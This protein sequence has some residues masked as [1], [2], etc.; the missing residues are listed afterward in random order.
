MS[1]PW[2]PSAGRAENANHA[3]SG[4]YAAVSSTTMTSVAIATTSP[5]GEAVGAGDPASGSAG[6]LDGP[7]GA[8][9]DA[10]VG[11][12]AAGPAV[13]R[14]TGTTGAGTTPD[15]AEGDPVAAEGDPDGAAVAIAIGVAPGFG[16]AAGAVDVATRTT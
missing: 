13:G 10:F 5:V 6:R 8:L 2:L 15:G 9:D 14:A 11:A 3:P 1:G 12:V 16:E 7:D 4:E